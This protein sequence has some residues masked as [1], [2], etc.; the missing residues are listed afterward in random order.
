VEYGRAV[1]VKPI[2]KFHILVKLEVF[3]YTCLMQSG[4]D[5]FLLGGRKECMTTA[6]FIISRTSK[7]HNERIHKIM[8]LLGEHSLLEIGESLGITY[9]SG[10]SVELTIPILR[11]MARV[12]HAEDVLILCHLGIGKLTKAS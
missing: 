10:I 8:I 7:L 3:L 1:S 4:K 6:T 5:Y 11:T 9:R 12:Y 2:V